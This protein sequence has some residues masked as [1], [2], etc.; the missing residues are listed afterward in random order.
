MKTNNTPENAPRITRAIA[1]VLVLLL[2]LAG[3]SSAQDTTDLASDIGSAVQ[4]GQLDEDAVADAASDIAASVDADALVASAS[5]IAGTVGSDRC[6]DATAAFSGIPQS[7][8]SAASGGVDSSE[9]AAQA[10]ALQQAIDDAPDEI[11]DDLQTV[12]DTFEEIA[13]GVADLDLE[14]GSVPDADQQAELQDLAAMLGDSD[15]TDA[16]QTVGTYFAS[17]C[18]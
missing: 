9:M 16:S 13:A 11:A 12:A 2:L 6:Q 1:P 5:E 18:E 17:G 10:D 14:A 15:F 4:D 7:L 8:T 3:C